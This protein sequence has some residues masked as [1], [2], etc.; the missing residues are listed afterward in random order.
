M[1][2][3]CRSRQVGGASAWGPGTAVARGGMMTAGGH[4]GCQLAVI[5]AV[6]RDARDPA[7]V[8]L[9][10]ELELTP[11]PAMLLFLPLALAEQLQPRAVDQQQPVRYDTRPSASENAAAPA[12]CSVVRH[13]ELE[14]E[15]PEYAADEALGLAPRR[16]GRAAAGSAP[17]RSPG[18]SSGPDRPVLFVALPA[19]R[20]PPPRPAKASGRPLRR[21]PAS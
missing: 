1:R 10:S 16:A 12:Q 2:P 3:T 6:R 8:G 5:G 19:S 15:Q 21:R 20:P 17:A 9:E 11:G 14:P 18:T 4:P 7:R 13:V